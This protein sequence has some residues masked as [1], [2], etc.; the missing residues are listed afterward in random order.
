MTPDQE[1]ATKIFKESLENVAKAAQNAYD[2][3]Q[4]LTNKLKELK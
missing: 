4:I 1:K 3:T 2:S